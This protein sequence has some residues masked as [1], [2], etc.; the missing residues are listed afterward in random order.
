MANANTFVTAIVHRGNDSFG[1]SFPDLPG[2]V[3]QGRTQQEAVASA[4]D[5]VAFHVEGLVSGGEA[6]PVPRSLDDLRA[7]PE[8]ADD[9]AGADALVLVPLTTPGRSVRINLTMDENLLAAID[10]AAERSGA[11]RSGF[12]ADAARAKLGAG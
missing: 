12:L 7:D 6:V 9:F 2:C 5:A 11:T 8:F 10:R 1:V 4:T 3:A